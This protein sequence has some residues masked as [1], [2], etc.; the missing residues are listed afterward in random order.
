MG[1]VRI[2]CNCLSS[3]K[4]RRSPWTRQAILVA[5]FITGALP[6][7]RGRRKGAPE[8]A[9]PLDGR[10][11]SGHIVPGAERGLS[12]FAELVGGQAVTTELK[13]VVNPAVGGKEPLRVTR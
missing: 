1:T 7:W 8:L 12:D 2:R 11:S 10:C 6:G 5:Q 3:G 4:R 13:V 9:Q